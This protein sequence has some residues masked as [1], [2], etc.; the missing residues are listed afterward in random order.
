MKKINFKIAAPIFFATFL[1]ISISANAAMAVPL[2]TSEQTETSSN[3]KSKLCP[4]RLT[5]YENIQIQQNMS[6]DGKRCYLGVHPRDAFETLIYR[7]YLL[8]D[9]GLL[10]VFNSFSASLRAPSDGAREFYFLPSEFT[11]FEWKVEG[12]HLVVTGFEDRILKFSLKTAQL[13]FI[14]GAEVKLADKVSVDNKGGLEILNPQ[15]VLIDAGFKFGDSPSS[16]KTKSSVFTNAL[17]KKCTLKNTKVY[18]YVDE[19]AYLKDLAA[20]RAAVE[21]TCPGFGI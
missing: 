18:D 3:D 8:T 5:G 19:S 12:E 21:A 15:F 17:G 2:I 6:S 4:D 11:G 16:D 9:D 20:L 10:M 14:S 13:E 7:D 1:L